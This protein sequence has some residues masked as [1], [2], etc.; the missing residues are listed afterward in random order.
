[1]TMH[2]S[3]ASRRRTR[4]QKLRDLPGC[5][6]ALADLHQPQHPAAFPAL[7]GL[8]HRQPVSCHN[9]EPPPPSDT[10]EEIIPALSILLYHSDVNVSF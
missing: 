5:G 4:V 10:I 3:C 6:A 1:M 7:R 2:M 9:K 8:S